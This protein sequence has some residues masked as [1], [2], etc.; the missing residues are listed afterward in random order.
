MMALVRYKLMGSYFTPARSSNRPPNRLKI[1]RKVI[2]SK[3]VKSAPG[4]DSGQ[5]DGWKVLRGQ[6]FI[7]NVK[8]H[9]EALW[10]LLIGIAPGLSN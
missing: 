9:L 7:L 4:E 10:A 1:K 2:F 6:F 5:T 3:V 8:T